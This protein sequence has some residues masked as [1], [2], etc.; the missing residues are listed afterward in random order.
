MWLFWLLHINLLFG[1]F[2]PTLVLHW[3]TKFCSCSPPA[4]LQHSDT[5]LEN[6]FLA[7]S[8]SAGVSITGV[9]PTCR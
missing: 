4:P 5:T 1:I 7:C 6:L 9:T 2:L 3:S 8:I